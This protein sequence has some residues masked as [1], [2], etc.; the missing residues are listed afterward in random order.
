MTDTK[1]KITAYD[2][3]EIEAYF[4]LHCEGFH[5]GRITF[6]RLR[7][8]LNDIMVYDRNGV[9]WTIG[10]GSGAWYRRDGDAWVRG[11]PHSPVYSARRITEAIAAR[12][13]A[14]SGCGNYYPSQYRFCPHCGTAAESTPQK[15]G[16]EQRPAAGER[17]QPQAVYC[18]QC[19][20]Q[21]KPQATFCSNCGARRS[22]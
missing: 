18:R 10:A 4:S 11:T 5:E 13:R 14:C 1:E 2:P 17:E 16:A 9:L 12:G 3:L 21:L 8:T 20:R 15:P 6:N 19:G 22:G 7:E